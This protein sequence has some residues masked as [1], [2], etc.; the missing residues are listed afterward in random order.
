MRQIFPRLNVFFFS[1]LCLQC[2]SGYS[3]SVEHN[4]VRG[5]LIWMHVTVGKPDFHHVRRIKSASGRGDFYLKSLFCC[6]KTFVLDATRNVVHGALL[7]NFGNG[8][9]F[10]SV[11]RFGSFQTHNCSL[12]WFDYSYLLTSLF[13]LLSI[14]SSNDFEALRV[15]L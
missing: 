4:T 15:A 3:L 14:F 2:Y 5:N 13:F 10:A 11:T 12:A 7:F 1:D 9:C 8:R 6:S